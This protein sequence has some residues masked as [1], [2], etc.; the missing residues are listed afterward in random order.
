MS[1]DG[2]H[3]I[4]APTLSG[5][6][7]VGTAFNI[8]ACARVAELR[9]EKLKRRLDTRDEPGRRL[10]EATKRAGIQALDETFDLLGIPIPET[11]TY[12]D[13]RGRYV[14]VVQEMIACGLAIE[15]AP[16]CVDLTEIQ[17]GDDAIHGRIRQYCGNLIFA[18][19][20]Y[21]T[22]VT[23]VDA[24]D[25]NEYLHVR[26]ADL[27]EDMV[28]E[29]RL[30]ETVRKRKKLR[31]PVL[32]YAHFPL[33]ADQDANVL[34]KSLGPDAAYDAVNFLRQLRSPEQRRQVMEN[35]VLEKPGHFYFDGRGRL[36]NVLRKEIVCITPEG[37][38]VGV[39][40]FFERGPFVERSQ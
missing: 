21:S 17:Y 35:M 4:V 28:P 22:I 13:R 25:F 24:I 7:H 10:S 38:R 1:V 20:P 30:F 14:E 6:P 16:G 8:L 27:L 39:R 3:V 15:T 5:R 31:R 29:V 11:Y 18:W 19:K 26:G 37:R 9:G 32:R 23:V 2:N 34:H 40:D 12:D 33:I 36:R